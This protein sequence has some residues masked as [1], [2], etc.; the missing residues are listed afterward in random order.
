MVPVPWVPLAGFHSKSSWE[1][2]RQWCHCGFIIET[3]FCRRNDQHGNTGHKSSQTLSQEVTWNFPC[4]EQEKLFAVNQWL[5]KN[6]WG[7]LTHSVCESLEHETWRER[8]GGF[9]LTDPLIIISPLESF[10]S[11]SWA[12]LRNCIMGKD[13][14]LYCMASFGFWLWRG[15]TGILKK[16]RFY[17]VTRLFNCCS[18][19][20]I[21]GRRLCRSSRTRQSD[22]FGGSP[23]RAG[24]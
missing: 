8:S 12:F 20:G 3:R 10:R 24:F 1:I 9:K 13:I 15:G 6:L 14:T 11:S 23:L 18:F 22:L 16:S 4:A 5:H 19:V 17:S 21:F 2:L 7:L